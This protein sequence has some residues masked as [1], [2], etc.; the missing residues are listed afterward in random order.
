M[1]LL[2]ILALALAAVLLWQHFRYLRLRRRSAQ[3]RQALLH[4]NSNFHLLVFFRLREGEKLLWSAGRFAAGV[5]RYREVELVYGGQAA[6]ALHSEQ[7]GEVQWSGVLLFS[8]P[9][10]AH[11]EAM[12]GELQSIAEDVFAQHHFH[13]MR[14]RR[15]LSLALPQL[16]LALRLRDIL[17]GRWRVA[18]LQRLPSFRVSADKDIWRRRVDRLQALHK[19]NTE[20]LVV[21]NLMRSGN[22]EQRVANRHYSR[23]ML[24][25]MA[26]L[27]HG[28]LHIGQAVDVDGQ[29]RFDRV[30]VVFYPSAR[31]FAEL[32][33]S[34]FFQKLFASKQLADTLAVPTVPMTERLLA[35]E[36]Q[37]LPAQTRRA[38]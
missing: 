29:A 33:A 3:D 11:Y 9:E 14:R 21:F 36:E 28:P 12:H 37:S 22:R 23:A 20:G 31:Y 16:L 38:A 19:V 10:R 27:G 30:V 34:E 32:I 35:Y 6:F 2:L 25:R 24:E 5:Q 18:P 13:G 17:R 15:G 26:A 7:L 8:F 4:P 1:H